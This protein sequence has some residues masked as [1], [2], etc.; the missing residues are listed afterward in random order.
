MDKHILKPCPFCGG[1][2]KF[3]LLL[4]NHVVVCTNCLGAI[5]PERRMTKD[6]AAKAWNTRTLMDNIINRLDDELDLADKEK[7]RCTRE[8]TLQFDTAKGYASG[9]YNS[10]EL[11]K[12]GGY[13]GRN[14]K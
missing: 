10:L 5:F 1:R 13:N 9:V 7:E 12:A 3:S 8:N 2:A 14:Q 6:E 11:V 4:G